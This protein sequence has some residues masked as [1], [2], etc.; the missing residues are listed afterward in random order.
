MRT[1]PTGTH[2]PTEYSVP[3][4][5][6]VGLIGSLAAFLVFTAGAGAA[7][8]HVTRVAR[9]PA[10]VLTLEVGAMEPMYT[11]QEAKESHP[12]SGEVMIGTGMSMPAGGHAIGMEGGSIRS[13]A[14][15]VRRRAGGTVVTDVRPAIALQDET[16]KST[17]S[18][19]QAVAMEGIDAGSSDLHYGNNVTL[20]PGHRYRVTVAVKG[21]RAAFVFR[22]R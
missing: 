15:H 16:V 2:T 1:T 3:M 11:E 12:A 13:V 10:Y 20:Q 7:G 5:A 21:Q 14:L 22:A 8:W 17:A 9:T 18:P 4:P 6:R 19:I